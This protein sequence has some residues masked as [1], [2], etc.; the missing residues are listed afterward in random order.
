MV[1][2]VSVEH[3]HHRHRPRGT[4]P[5]RPRRVDRVEDAVVWILL[6]MALLVG[7]SAVFTGT[8]E[9]SEALERA[10]VESAERRPVE[11]VLESP[12]TAVMSTDGMGVVGTVPVPATWQGVGG[13]PVR[14]DVWVDAG[15]PRGATTTVWLDRNGAPAAPPLSEADAITVGWLFGAGVAVF[16]WGVLA[17]LWWVTHQ[18]AAAAR[19]A[20]WARDWARVEPEWRA[21]EL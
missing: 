19:S 7:I 15:L 18:F 13:V 3:P 21:H 4:Q 14:A 11:A 1:L 8:A 17:L 6:V 16:G 12:S 5:F 9:H 2:R 20:H 10:A